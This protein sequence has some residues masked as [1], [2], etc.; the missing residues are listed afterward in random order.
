M[1]VFSDLVDLELVVP[2]VSELT[3]LSG[4]HT[5]FTHGITDEPFILHSD[6]ESEDDNNLVSGPAR[7]I[8]EGGQ[9]GYDTFDMEHPP[10]LSIRATYEHGD[11]NIGIDKTI[12]HQTMKRQRSISPSSTSTSSSR[13]SIMSLLPRNEDEEGSRELVSEAGES[14]DDICSK[15][16]KVSTPQGRRTVS[17]NDPSQPSGTLSV[18][19]EDCGEDDGTLSSSLDA[20]LTSFSRSPPASEVTSRTELDVCPMVTDVDQDW[21]VREI[22]GKEDLDGV[23]YYLVDW[24]PTL[25]PG[26]SLGHAKELVQKFEARIRAQR[27]VNH[28]RGGLGSKARQKASVEAQVS[29]GQQGKKPRG[30]PRKQT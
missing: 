19:D 23:T 30:R 2:M 6:G 10:M 22:I 9:P 21:D 28:K 24:H 16:R 3:S 14:G 18:G 27:G 26:H 1:T 12:S 17:C 4:L 13:G 15:R 7:C 20:R 29:S 25:L 5:I 11:G 8:V